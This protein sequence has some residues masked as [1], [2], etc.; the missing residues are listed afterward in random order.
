MYLLKPEN[1]DFA[2]RRVICEEQPNPILNLTWD[3]PG[4]NDTLVPR[5]SQ[6][7]S[8]D[9]VTCFTA[10]PGLWYLW[11]DYSQEEKDSGMVMD[12]ADIK[13]YVQNSGMSLAF[14]E[15]NLHIHGSVLCTKKDYCTDLP[16]KATQIGVKNNPIELHSTI[17]RDGTFLFE[18]LKSGQWNVTLNSAQYCFK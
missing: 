8:A 14:T 18:R 12:N 3:T 1:D 17:K 6:S 4:I 10:G 9:G 5:R 16:I 13:A 11:F 7:I 2:D 15:R